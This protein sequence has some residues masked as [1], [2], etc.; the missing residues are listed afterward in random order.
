[1]LSHTGENQKRLEMLTTLRFTTSID[2]MMNN[3]KVKET[4]K[5]KLTD[6]LKDQQVSKENTKDNQLA[7][8]SK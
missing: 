4:K 3:N 8:L 5:A 6:M 1:M 2:K 7:K